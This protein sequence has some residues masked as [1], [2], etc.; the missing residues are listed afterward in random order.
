MEHYLG[1]DINIASLSSIATVGS[2]PGNEFLPV[3]GDRSLPS[4]AALDPYKCCICEFWH[5]RGFLFW[6]VRDVFDRSGPVC[7]K[8]MKDG[9]NNKSRI[10]IIR[11]L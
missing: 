1:L 4:V 11:D 9:I 3:K 10:I 2:A 7:M 5:L 8:T 6:M